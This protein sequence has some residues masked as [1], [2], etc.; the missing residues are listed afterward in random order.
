MPLSLLGNDPYR[1]AV[2]KRRQLCGHELHH[3][4]RIL[5]YLLYM[6]GY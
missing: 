4:A 3:L 1:W 5:L 2:T 6:I